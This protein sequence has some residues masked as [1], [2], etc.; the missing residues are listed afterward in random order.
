MLTPAKKQAIDLVQSLL[1]FA[2][3]N[4][5]IIGLELSCIFTLLDDY[6]ALI[7]QE[8]LG[9]LLEN[10]MTFDKFIFKHVADSQLPF[11]FKHHLLHAKY[12]VHCYQ[13]S[14]E[15]SKY[16]TGVLKAIPRCHTSEIKSGCCGMAGAF[17]YEKEHYQISMDIGNLSLFPSI[18][19]T[20]PTTQIITNGYSCRSQIEQG[21]ERQ[22]LHLAEFI[23][24]NIE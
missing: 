16:I 12:H 14:L 4:L 24:Q 19:Y 6:P 9:K 23:A 1:P 21:T 13:K 5:P 17:G 11:K 20:L 10:A 3:E 2:V 7:P 18:K 8:Q 15:G 22:A